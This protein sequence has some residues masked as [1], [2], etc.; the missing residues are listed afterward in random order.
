MAGSGVTRCSRNQASRHRALGPS[1][2]RG[3]VDHQSQCRNSPA[4]APDGRCAANRRGPGRRR[5]GCPP[6]RGRRKER[7]RPGRA[8]PA[9]QTLPTSSTDR[10]TASSPAGGV[11]NKRR[12]PSRAGRSERRAPPPVRVPLHTRLAEVHRNLAQG[13]PRR[14]SLFFP[15]CLL[16]TA[17]AHAVSLAGSSTAKRAPPAPVSAH[18]PRPLG[19][20]PAASADVHRV[21]DGL[22]VRPRIQRQPAVE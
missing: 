18:A 4:F 14:R 9:E 1:G 6:T 10:A 22:W 21:R 7:S 15:T 20:R 12:K 3:W 13:S 2:G 16:H 8:S 11:R 5:A 19:P 17:S